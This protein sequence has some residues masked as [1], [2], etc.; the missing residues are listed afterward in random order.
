LAR[1]ASSAYSVV[2]SLALPSGPLTCSVLLFSSMVLAWG[3]MLA[4]SS[5]LWEN[6]LPDEFE[7]SVQFD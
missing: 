3:V 5:R 4:T 2:V 6:G 7:Q 1:P